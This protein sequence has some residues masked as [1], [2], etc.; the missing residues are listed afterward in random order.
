MNN[1]IGKLMIAVLLSTSSVSVLAHEMWLEPEP[2]ITESN[3]DLKAHI[4]VGQN[5]SGEKFPY[6]KSETKSLKLFLTQ[7]E[8]KLKHRDGDYPAI[9]SLLTSP[10]LYVL[11]YESVA[12][13]VNYANF[14]KFKSFLEEQNVW[15]NWSKENPSFINSTINEIYTRYAKS[16]VQVGSTSEE[17]FNT[18]LAFELIAIDNPY[19][20]KNAKGIDVLLL[21][22]NKPFANSQITVF[23]KLNNKVSIAKTTTDSDGKALISLENKGLY[24]VSAVHFIKAEKKSAD[25]H[26]LWA[27]LTFEK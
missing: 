25:W 27:S 10:G 1:F 6:I 20:N 24:L 2:F 9:Q 14:E 11:S 16:L 17:D 13:K 15:E 12:E 18:G 23:H 19:K 22:Q 26:S 5:F 3:T 7:K 4:K 8:I 21:Y